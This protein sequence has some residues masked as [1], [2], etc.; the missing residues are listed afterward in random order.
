MS[1][2]KEDVM[3]FL[4][5]ALTF[6]LSSS[7]VLVTNYGF[8]D[9]QKPVHFDATFRYV[10]PAKFH[11]KPYK[12]T[13]L[14]Y[15]DGDASLYYSRFVNENNALSA[16]VGY[17]HMYINWKHNP[18]FTGTSY[19][20]GVV[21]LGWISTGLEGWRWILST[22]MSTSLH[23]SFANN[24]V[25]F[26][27]AWGKYH[28]KKNTHIHIG[29][30]LFAGVKNINGLPIIGAD[31]MLGRRWMFAAVF[32]FDIA[33]RYFISPKWYLCLSAQAFGIPYRFPQRIRGGIG[34]FKDGIFEL[35]SNAADISLNYHDDSRLMFTLGGG[36]NLGGWLLLKN[37]H[38]HHGRYYN[39][40][41]AFY[42]QANI[43]INF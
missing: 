22:A 29:Y 14:D 28:F 41:P 11:T 3:K 5:L 33:M 8:I 17:Y 15:H 7:F 40:N 19:D 23:G 36:Y 6:C 34:P 4:P 31:Y 20:Y 9:P 26:V 37:K 21:S 38:N 16:Q 10:A 35:Y 2:K 43:G 30:Y 24:A 32:P 18:L 25:G 13:H 27:T 42:A 12:N 1:I 39:Y